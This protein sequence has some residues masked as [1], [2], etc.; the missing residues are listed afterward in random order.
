MLSNSDSDSISD[1]V[2]TNKGLPYPIPFPAKKNSGSDSVSVSD[3]KN[4]Y[5][6]F[7]FSF[8]LKTCSGSITSGGLVDSASAIHAVGTWFEYGRFRCDQ[9]LNYWY[10]LFPLAR[11]SALKV[12][13]SS[14][15]TLVYKEMKLGGTY[16]AEEEVM[17][18]L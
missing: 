1:S 16:V 2:P 11:R 7:R 13:K 5:F 14:N 6:R 12:L 18:N 4:V 8:R 10:R 15:E 3:I 17:Q 9:S